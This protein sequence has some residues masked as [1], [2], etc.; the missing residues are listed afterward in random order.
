M[1][2]LEAASAAFSYVF[3]CK[4]CGSKCEADASDLGY[5]PGGGDQRESWEESF[6]I[7]CGVCH[8]ADYVP[9]GQVP[10]LV[11]IR[12][13]ESHTTSSDRYGR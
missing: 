3:T 1:K 2:V 11:K 13:R 7:H 6:T 9:S 5:N 12:V 10:V 4:Q 8:H